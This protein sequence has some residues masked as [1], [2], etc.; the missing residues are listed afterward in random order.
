MKNK[1]LSKNEIDTFNNNGFMIKKNLFN[2]KEIAL[3]SKNVNELASAE[4]IPKDIMVYL[5]KSVINPKINQVSRIEKFIPY[6]EYLT[7]I[8]HDNRIM[9]TLHDLFNEPAILFKDKINY[10]LPG[11]GCSNPHQD[12]QA[13]WL[14]YADYFISVQ[15][16]IDQN[17]IDNGCLEI[18][19]NRNKNLIANLWEPL[20]DSLLENM[21]F[22]NFCCEPGDCIFF[23]CFVPH[24]SAPNLSNHSRRNLYIT[25]NKKS[26]GD[27]RIKY[28]IDKRR[29]FPPNN[30]RN[31]DTE[32]K[33]KV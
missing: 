18:S 5:E 28:F 12:I 16:A 29:S 24:K 33:F 30:E 19:K 20:P 17:T 4:P 15:I 32:Y 22:E 10:K 21:I 13:N 7:E 8:C 11:E 27:N 14:E 31:S 3:I 2:A 1:Y 23:D 26:A 25:Y 6:N 9:K